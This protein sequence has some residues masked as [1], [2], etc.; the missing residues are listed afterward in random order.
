MA[1]G[2]YVGKIL[3]V[4]LT[5][6]KTEEIPTK[7]YQS[8]GGGHGIGAALFWDRVKD[9]TID[10]FHPDNLVSFTT[11]PMSGTGVP[12]AS[13][14]TEIT[15]IGVQAYP[16][17]WLTRSNFGGRWSAMLKYAG[18]DG[19]A[20]QGRADKP[21][22]INIVNGKVTIESAEDLWGLNTH[23]T[24]EEIWKL[25]Q[26]DKDNR[27]WFDIGKSRDDGRTTQKPAVVCIGPAGENKNRNACV[28]HDAGN[29]GGQGGFGGVLGAKNLKAISVLGNGSVPIADPAALLELRQEIKDKFGYNVDDPKREAPIPGIPMYGHTTNEPGYAGMLWTSDEPQR[30]Q[31][32]QGCFKNCRRNFAS[33]KGNGDICVESLWSGLAMAGNVQGGLAA[34]TLLDQLGLNA[35]DLGNGRPYLYALYKQGILGP[36]KQI[37]SNLPWDK[38]DTLEW[39]EAFL[40]CLAEGTDI[41]ADLKEG[42]AR[43]AVKWGRWEEDTN[44]GLLTCPQ[45]GYGEHYDP[46]LEVEWSYGSLFGDRDINEHGVN[47]HVHWMP[48]IGGVFGEAPAMTAE[49]I[50]KHIAEATGVG[51]PK[52]W[53]YSPEGIYSD[54]KLKAVSWHRH[55]T[56]FWLQSML[57]CDWAWPQLASYNTEDGKGATPDYEVKLYKAVTGEDLTY[58]QSL[59]LGQKIWNLGRAIWTLQGRTREMEVFTGYVYDVPTS[60]PYPLPVFKDGA[61]TYDVCLGR[62]L[63]REK[64]EGVKDRFYKL[65]GWDTKTGWPTRAGLEKLGLS[66]VADELEKHGKLGGNPS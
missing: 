47:W 25:V 52:G 44:R 59:E 66:N 3:Y 24:Q 32:C 56:R 15:G 22:W 35:Y 13:G 36:G 61:W 31:G 26:G 53:D 17:D 34:A 37:E 39:I 4:N 38:W 40:T 23:E 18:F 8:W 51:D 41:G 1:K 11:S 33:G 55:Y 27:D 21:V 9:K 19:I 10:G 50:T 12:S 46:R 60:V 64:F 16:G 57:M 58:E 49:E 42:F 48:L 45:W 28:L 2:G 29:A 6:G 54:A 14:R 62:T 5:T 63:D 43:A 30:P 7:Q 65:E 20:V